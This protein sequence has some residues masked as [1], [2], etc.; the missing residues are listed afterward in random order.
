MELRQLKYFLAVAEEGLIVKAAERLNI[1]QPPL[2][3]QL[4]QLE[5][6]LGTQ[7]FIRSRKRIQLTESG[8]ILQRRAVQMLELMNRTTQEIDESAHAISGRLAL[9]VGA[10]FS[11]A[12]LP[13]QVAAFHQQYPAVTFELHQGDTLKIMELLRIGIIEIGFVRAPFNMKEFDFILLPPEPMLF[14]ACDITGA[15]ADEPVAFPTLAGKPLLLHRRHIALI[16]QQCQMQGFEPLIFCT[17]DDT[18]QLLRWAEAGLGIAVVPESAGRF[19][20]GQSLQ[21][22]RPSPSA[23][24]TTG[25]IIYPRHLPFSTAAA[26]FIQMLQ[27]KSKTDDSHA[28]PKIFSAEE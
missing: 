2:S 13:R 26:H 24:T 9:G 6:E 4:M 14:A 15:A 16:T 20:A 21:F 7:L 10:S 8:R 25:A 28:V 22:Y 11:S 1:T 19:A 23:L 17:S 3:Q 5:K 27:T 12:M 18:L